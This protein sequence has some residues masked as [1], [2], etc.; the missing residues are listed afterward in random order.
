MKGRI[1]SVSYSFVLAIKKEL[2]IKEHLFSIKHSGRIGLK[3]I[4]VNVKLLTYRKKFI[5]AY[6]KLV[7]TIKQKKLL[8][9]RIYLKRSGR[10]ITCVF[11]K[12]ILQLK[13]ANNSCFCVV[14]EKCI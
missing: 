7:L 14:C 8:L 11:Q 5:N 4:V 1:S 6:L 10:Y 12:M 3:K 9:F 2:F 13:K